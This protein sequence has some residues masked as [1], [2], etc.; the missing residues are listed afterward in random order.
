M[1]AI[2]C[3]CSDKYSKFVYA[4]HGHVH[5]G[6]LEI[7]ENKRLRDMS[8]GAKFREMPPCNKSKLYTMFEEAVANLKNKLVKLHT[9]L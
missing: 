1:Q 5:T 7:I 6:N 2:K 8:M 3:D 9:S 4:P